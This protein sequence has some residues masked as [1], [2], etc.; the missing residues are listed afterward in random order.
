[1]D[2]GRALVMSALQRSNTGFEV[3]VLYLPLTLHSA[4]E[5]WKKEWDRFCRKCQA[6]GMYIF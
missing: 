4:Q 1:M 2:V 3:V 5:Y 6:E